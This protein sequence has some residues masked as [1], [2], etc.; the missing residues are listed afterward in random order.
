VP[1]AEG[2]AGTAVLPLGEPTTER[3]GAEI[4]AGCS[5]WAGD[6]GVVV[7]DGF[8]PEEEPDVDPL[9]PEEGVEEA[10]PEVDEPP[11]DED[12]V[13]VEPEPELPEP[14]D[15]PPADPVETGGL[16]VTLPTP[17]EDEPLVPDLQF[18]PRTPSRHPALLPV[19]VEPPDD[20]AVEEW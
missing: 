18:A 4:T 20:A 19:E 11:P 17:P 13:G 7:T 10:G 2:T 12:A 8:A 16:I 6:G 9:V 3:R 5:G 1:S 15:E 14:E